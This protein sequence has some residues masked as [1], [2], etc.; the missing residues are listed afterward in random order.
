MDRETKLQLIE[1]SLGL[2]HKLRVHDSMKHPETHEDLAVMILAKWDFEDELRAIE[3]V[4]ADGRL[5]QVGD[6]K[7]R[8][9]KNIKEGEPP[10]KRKNTKKYSSED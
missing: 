1:R 8:I 4:M 10:V 7:K 2:R 3:E 6:L 5:S 9:L